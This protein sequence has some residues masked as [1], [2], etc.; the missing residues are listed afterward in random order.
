MAT[1]I[2]SH[3]LSCWTILKTLCIELIP[4]YNYSGRK[5][6]NQTIIILISLVSSFS[7]LC[8]TLPQLLIS[9]L[10]LYSRV[11]GSQLEATVISFHTG[12]GNQTASC[13]FQVGI[14]F[15]VF[16]QNPV[17]ASITE[18]TALLTSC[19]SCLYRVQDDKLLECRRVRCRHLWAIST[20]YCVW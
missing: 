12:A 4:P 20:P 18:H 10:K 15:P 6:W 9:A 2:G 14:C 13:K 5:M 7:K 3:F 11:E 17:L 8:Q 16:P 1:E 19:Q